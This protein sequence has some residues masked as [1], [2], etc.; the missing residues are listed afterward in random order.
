MSIQ[1]SYF[2]KNLCCAQFKERDC[3]N[4]I[5]LIQ[6]ELEK[7]NIKPYKMMSELGFS[8]GL[9][10]QWKSGKQKPSMEKIQKIAQYLD[11][12]TDYLL[13]GDDK[14]S[15]NSFLNSSNI[16]FGENSKVN[17]T[18][19]NEESKNEIIKEIS[20]IV[21]SLSLRERSELLTIIYK[22]VDEHKKEGLCNE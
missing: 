19:E 14:Y 21:L 8:S 18:T 5:Q 7:R 11:V 17:I 3:V 4:T 13:N 16:A 9:F 22:F 2:S 15:N 6:K 12:S 20:D 10:S 1:L